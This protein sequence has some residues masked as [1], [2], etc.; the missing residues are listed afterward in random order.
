MQDQKNLFLAF[1]ARTL[2]YVVNVIAQRPYA[3]CAAI[4]AD[5]QAQ[6]QQQ[7]KSPLTGGSEALPVLAD[8]VAPAM[9]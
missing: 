3:E 1:D 8:A 4:L 5:I 7:Q 2:D 6:V 9:Q